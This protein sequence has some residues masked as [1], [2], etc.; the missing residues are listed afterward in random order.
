[1]ITKETTRNSTQKL[2]SFAVGYV[3]FADVCV[4]EAFKAVLPRLTLLHNK[5]RGHSKSCINKCTR[6][7]NN[8][9]ILNN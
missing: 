6:L 3:F 5:C 9:Y 2:F 8:K 1:M 4:V 7:R